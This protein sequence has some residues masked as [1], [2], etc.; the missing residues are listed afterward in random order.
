[1]YTAKKATVI[2]RSPHPEMFP[3]KFQGTSSLLRAFCTDFI[4]GAVLSFQSNG[5]VELWMKLCYLPFI[6]V[7]CLWTHFI[8]LKYDEALKFFCHYQEQYKPLIYLS[9]S[10]LPSAYSRCPGPAYRP[11]EGTEFRQQCLAC[12]PP[13]LARA[14]WTQNRYE[15]KASK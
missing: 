10:C 12:H 11:D 2:V 5:K 9:C 14:A 15:S 8:I 7:T 1:M 13:Y 3:G 6:T 4:W